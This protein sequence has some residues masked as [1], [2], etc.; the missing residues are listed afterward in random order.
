VLDSAKGWASV[1]RNNLR[2]SEEFDRF[3]A[4]PDTLSLGVC[5]GCQ[6]MGLL[7]I[8]GF[9]LPDSL[10]PRFIRNAS[11]RFESRFSTVRVAKS[12]AVMLQ[13]MEGSVLGIWVAHGEGRLHVPN[14]ATLDWIVEKGLAPVRYADPRGDIATA[15]PFNPNGSPLG[16]AALCSPDGRHLAMMPHPERTFQL[17]QWPW[18]PPEWKCTT[19]PWLRLFRNAYAAFR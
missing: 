13:G 7:G 3:F 4:R 6:L 17:R 5:N 1:I 8:P 12:L 14:S 2:L 18:V 19:S 11:E 16:I 15:Y 9:D 10:K